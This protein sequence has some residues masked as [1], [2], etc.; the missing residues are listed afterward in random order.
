MKRLKQIPVPLAVVIMVVCIVVGIAFGNHNALSEAK[1]APEAILAEVSALASQRANSAKNL[2]VVANRN[3][4]DQALRTQLEDTIG[5]LE[6]AT[7]AGKIAS[8]NEGLT[9]ATNAVNEQIQA[10]A[11]DQ[12]KRLATGVMD[13]LSSNDKLL[14]RRANVYNESLE[15]VSKVYRTLPFGW[16]VGGMPEVH[17]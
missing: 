9:F 11:N 14:T 3:N 13:D 6:D 15:A 17:Q 2:L 10:N 16:L 5:S 4:V 1:A 8:A 12:D 7:K